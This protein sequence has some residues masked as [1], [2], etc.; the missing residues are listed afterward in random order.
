M[1]YISH[2]NF[3]FLFSSKR[4]LYLTVY[5]KNDLRLAYRPKYGTTELDCSSELYTWV[6][7][8]LADCKVETRLP[9]I[10]SKLLQAISLGLFI[11]DLLPKIL[12]DSI[13]SVGT[14]QTKSRYT[15]TAIV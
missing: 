13:S 14:T 8:V 12:E 15:W 1:Y 10:H 2:L 11:G 6:K 4:V 7:Q 9:Q 3:S 5:F